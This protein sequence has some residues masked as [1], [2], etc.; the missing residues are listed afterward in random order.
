MSILLF[1]GFL[2]PFTATVF[3]QKAA[4]GK[5]GQ[6]TTET[7]VN[8]SALDDYISITSLPADKKRRAFREASPADRATFFRLHL[9]LQ[10]V[11]LPD[12]TE[13]QAKLVLDAISVINRDTYDVSNIEKRALAERDALDLQ[14]RSLSV[15]SPIKTSEIFAGLGGGPDE[16]EVLTRY[17]SIIRVDSISD[18]KSLFRRLSVVER[19]KLW[20]IQLAYHLATDEE[21]NS[22]Q[23][24]ILFRGIKIL[25]STAL[26]E[27]CEAEFAGTALGKELTELELDAIASFDKRE[28]NKV[29]VSLGGSGNCTIKGAYVT[30]VNPDCGCSL[31]YNDCTQT[32]TCSSGGCTKSCFGC[33]FLWLQS[34]NGE[35]R[36]H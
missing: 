29:F 20:A 24:E 3:P 14:N 16:L 36:R 2:T 30:E 12:L 13:A 17:Q 1:L 22:H 4:L 8:Y 5:V 18:R 6:A 7:A 19:T 15:F 25:R 31:S 9:A 33:G 11:K 26:E 34:C 28:F 27:N 23:K 32:T 35:C 21:L 10:L